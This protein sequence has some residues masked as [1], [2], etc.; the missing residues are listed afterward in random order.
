MSEYFESSSGD[1]QQ[2]DVEEWLEQ[3]FI[4]NDLKSRCNY[5]L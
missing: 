4:L 5:A 1:E 3:Y 2:S